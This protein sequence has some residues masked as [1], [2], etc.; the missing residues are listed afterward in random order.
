VSFLALLIHQVDVSNPTFPGGVNRYGDPDETPTVTAGVRCRVQPA[1]GD[2]RLDN[3]DTRTTRMRVFFLP[4]APIT[5][6]ST[7]TWLG[8]TLR[9]SA[10]PEPYY[11]SGALHHYEVDTEEVLG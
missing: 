4:D 10:E 8:R 7:L 5:A 6:L 3:R 2:E 9:V 11:D 1:G